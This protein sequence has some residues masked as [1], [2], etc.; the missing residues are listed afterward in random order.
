MLLEVLRDKMCYILS[1]E[2]GTNTSGEQYVK[3]DQE[4]IYIYSIIQSCHHFL[5][6][7]CHRWEFSIV[8]HGLN[9]KY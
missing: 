8:M 4:K 5:S 1:E 7:V 3:R 9:T 2:S 6:V